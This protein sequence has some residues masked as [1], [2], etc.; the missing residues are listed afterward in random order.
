MRKAFDG[1]CGPV[2]S[3]LLALKIGST[4]VRSELGR[5]PTSDKVFVLRPSPGSI[6]NC[7]IGKTETLFVLQAT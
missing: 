2:Y 3:Q 7:C 6:P 1:L 4:S 5:S